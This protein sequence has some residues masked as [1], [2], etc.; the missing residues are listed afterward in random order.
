MKFTSLFED[1]TFE[2]KLASM[3]ASF[4]VC[5]I[6]RPY[7]VRLSIVVGSYRESICKEYK[8]TLELV[9]RGR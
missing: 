6:W 3:R 4:R 1:T 9:L 7:N 2:N 8:K 5:S